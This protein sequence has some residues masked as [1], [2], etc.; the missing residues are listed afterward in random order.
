MSGVPN[1][2]PPLAPD[3]AR[4]F[5]ARYRDA[6]NAG[7]AAAVAA[8]WHESSAIADAPDGVARLSCWPEP[9]AMR[10]NMAALCRVYAE[11]GPHAWSFELREGRPLGAHHFF[12]D[13]EWSLRRASGEL[14][15]R[16]GT[17]Y[18]LGRTAQGWRVLFCCA[19]QEDLT[20]TRKHAAE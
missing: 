7:D 20:E 5:F 9:A 6:F 17:G 1:T 18:Q 3:Q 12:A 8:L 11:L 14:L 15:Q 4:D 2:P 16:F 13:V 19:Y 10:A